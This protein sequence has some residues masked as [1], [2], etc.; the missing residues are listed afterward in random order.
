MFFIFLFDK[1]YQNKQ[2]KRDY[3]G[4]DDVLTAFLTFFLFFKLCFRPFVSFA[5]VFVIV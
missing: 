1:K 5:F 2:I 4:V 3:N